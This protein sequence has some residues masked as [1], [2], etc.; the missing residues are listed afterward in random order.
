MSEKEE[1]MLYIATHAGEDPEKASIPFVLANAALAMDIQAMVVLQGEAVYLAKKG[2]VDT[3]LPK[4]GFPP[5]KKL[6]EEFIELGGQLRI[7]VPCIKSRNIEESDLIAG[8]EATAAGAL[9][10]AAMEADAVFT[11]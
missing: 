2:Y 4:G 1:K 6:V 7:C 9:N 8:A 11:Y 3:V 10:A 5:I